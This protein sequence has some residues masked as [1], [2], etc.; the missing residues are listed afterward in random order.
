[1]ATS[2]RCSAGLALYRR[3]EGG[4]EILLV[5]PGGPFFARKDNGSWSLPKGLVEDEEDRLRAARREFTEETGIPTPEEGY[6]D[7]GEVTQKGGKVVCAWAFEGDCD[8]SAIRSNTFE[9]EWPPRSGRIREFPEIDRAAF[10]S[11]K[12]ARV[13]LNPAQAAFVDRLEEHL[14]AGSTSG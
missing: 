12:E 13:K 9:L 3:S 8:P 10:F 6:L 5:H 1:M 14:R 11:L 7:L 2:S 4:P